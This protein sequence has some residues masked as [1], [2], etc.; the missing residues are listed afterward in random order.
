VSVAACRDEL[1]K[2]IVVTE[3][4]AHVKVAVKVK[5]KRKP[6]LMIVRGWCVRRADGSGD[7]AAENKES[8]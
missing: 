5:Q 4:E 1:I 8:L 7:A 3:S 2:I 6:I